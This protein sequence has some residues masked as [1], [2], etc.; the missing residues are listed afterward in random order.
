M[1]R[2]HGFTVKIKSAY[3]QPYYPTGTCIECF[4][5]LQNLKTLQ[6]NFHQI[7]VGMELLTHNYVSH[8]EKKLVCALGST[9]LIHFTSAHTV[10][11]NS[12]FI[13]ILHGCAFSSFSTE[14][15][16]AKSHCVNSHFII[17]HGYVFSSFST[18][19]VQTR[20]YC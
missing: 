1:H 2:I 6:T 7:S 17:L 15:V 11:V 4:L 10:C 5:C 19:L 16:Q 3:T 18:E 20:S 12:H 14:L 13:I 8:M 9:S